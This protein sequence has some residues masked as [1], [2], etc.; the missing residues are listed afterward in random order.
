MKIAALAPWF[1]SKR[2]MAPEIVRVLGDH[3]CYWEPFC[4]SM[5]VLFAK[6]KC[7]M[8]TVNDLHGDLINLARVVRDKSASQE[9]RRQARLYMCSDDD[10]AASNK[11][12]RSGPCGNE[13]DIDRAMAYMA[14]SWMC[15]NGEAG[16]RES[17]TTSRLCV[18][19]GANGGDPGTRWAGVVRSIAYWHRRLEAVTVL[20]RCGF[21]VLEKIIDEPGAAIYCDPPY[22][23]KS[24]VYEHDF[25]NDD[26]DRLAETLNRFQHA[27]V[28][29][30]YYAHPRLK[31]LYPNWL[32][33][34]RPRAKN[35]GNQSPLKPKGQRN[36]APEVLLVKN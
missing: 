16:L 35:L 30:S 22:I 14:A 31:S 34:D 7:R 8:E 33:L 32:V 10:L 25:H 4:G 20:R 26:H 9:L 27:R 2:T 1:G 29:V 17:K 36:I 12:I 23:V 19:W 13:L 21:E 28:V 3:R 11:L 6:P 5:A 24:D 15:R 18:R